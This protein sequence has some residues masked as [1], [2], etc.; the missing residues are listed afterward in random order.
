[1]PKIASL[2]DELL[3]VRGLNMAT[4]FHN[5]GRVF[6]DTGIRN[7]TGEVNGASIPAIIASESSATIPI[8]Q[9]QGGADIL[10]DRAIEN[11]V[12]IVRANNLDLFKSMYPEACGYSNL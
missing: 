1:L 8:I 12:S 9:L 4:T 5:A 6:A 3:V 11:S 2:G 7:N 10:T